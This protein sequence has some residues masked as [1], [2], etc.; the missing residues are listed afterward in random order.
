MYIAESIIGDVVRY[1][2]GFSE[3][4]IVWFI[5]WYIAGT[6]AGFIVG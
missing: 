5:T 2:L 4:C 6:L 1:I 3:G